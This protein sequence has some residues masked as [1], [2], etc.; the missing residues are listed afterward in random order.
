MEAQIRDCLLA[1][2][3][4]LTATSL[5]TS[6]SLGAVDADFA[7]FAFS[8]TPISGPAPLTVHF[9]GTAPVRNDGGEYTIDYNDVRN[10]GTDATLNCSASMCTIS[11]DYTYAFSGTFTP[12]LVLTIPSSK[13]SCTGPPASDLAPW[14]DPSDCPSVSEVVVSATVT[15][16]GGPATGTLSATPLSGMGSVDV[17]FTLAGNG[18]P[19]IIESNGERSDFGYILDGKAITWTSRFGRV[20]FETNTDQ[21]HIVRLL[22]DGKVLQTATITVKPPRDAFSGTCEEATQKCRQRRLNINACMA[23]CMRTLAHWRGGL[24]RIFYAKASVDFA[25]RAFLCDVGEICR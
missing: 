3:V 11:G 10:A 21:I 23:D 4:I 6:V 5:A 12:T 22:S 24:T 9:T 13:P 18:G 17:T 8:A 19:F 25:T 16:T 2:V 20:G 1:F 7:D 14:G 15:V